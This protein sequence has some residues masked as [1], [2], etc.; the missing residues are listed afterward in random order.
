MQN[1]WSSSPRASTMDCGTL[2]HLSHASHPTHPIAT[3]S[4]GS[5]TSIGAGFVSSSCVSSGSGATQP[6][7]A[8][9]S[10]GFI[11]QTHSSSSPRA[12]A[13]ERGILR[14]F[15]H[16]S[17]PTHSNGSSAATGLGAAALPDFF[18]PPCFRRFVPMVVR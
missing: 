4:A 16:A 12:S 9:A 13:M 11:L 14:H 1:H 7:F 10:S 2:R 8:I 5:S 17:H 15:P 3:G 6:S 18:L